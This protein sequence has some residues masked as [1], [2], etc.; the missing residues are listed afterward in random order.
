[1]T[2]M[3]PLQT[4]E[5]Q[6][7]A[8][9]TDLGQRIDSVFNAASADDMDS[10]LAVITSHDAALPL[11]EEE[12]EEY[13]YATNL[14]GLRYLGIPSRRLPCPVTKPPRAQGY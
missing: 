7:E 11:L 1:M 14:A 2:N 8:E 4:K 6:R 3:V 12:L 10:R 5:W 13:R 9:V